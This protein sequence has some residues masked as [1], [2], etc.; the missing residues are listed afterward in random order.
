[1]RKKKKSE[2][3]S[4]FSDVAHSFHTDNNRTVFS[5]FILRFFFFF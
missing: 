2:T 1:M 3:K 5:L 4:I